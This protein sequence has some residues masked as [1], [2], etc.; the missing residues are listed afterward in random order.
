MNSSKLDL[1]DHLPI[2]HLIFSCL[3][4]NSNWTERKFCVVFSIYLRIHDWETMILA[5]EW[6]IA[7]KSNESRLFEL[8][9]TQTKIVREM[10]QN[11][12][13]Q[14]C[15]QFN[16][17]ISFN[18]WLTGLS[19]IN[20]LIHRGRQAHL[21]SSEHELLPINCFKIISPYAIASVLICVYVLSIF[22]YISLSDI[23][24]QNRVVRICS[25][26]NCLLCIFLQFLFLTIENQIDPRKTLAF[27]PLN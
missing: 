2:L 25:G 14:F 21:L 4:S 8:T 13:A 15:R 11:V 22:V 7:G 6:N 23:G 18:V 1:F 5:N 26:I 16:L 19:F 3:V 10:A 24:D 9:A 27:H 17:Q 20:V 12:N